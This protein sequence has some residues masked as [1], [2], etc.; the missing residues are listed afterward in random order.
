MST[1]TFRGL[2]IISLLTKV[3]G[4]GCKVATPTM[5]LEPTTP[6][7][8]PEP[9]T[10]APTPAA[11]AEDTFRGQ[12][13]ATLLQDITKFHSVACVTTVP[14]VV[15]PADAENNPSKNITSSETTPSSETSS[16]LLPVANPLPPFIPMDEV[17]ALEL[18]TNDF[19][20]Q[21]SDKCKTDNQNKFNDQLNQCATYLTG[22]FSANSDHTDTIM[23]TFIS[24]FIVQQGCDEVAEPTTG[25][26]EVFRGESVAT[27]LK[28]IK[29]FDEAACSVTGTGVTGTGGTGTGGTGTGG[30]GT[31]GTGTG[32]TGTGG[33]G[34]GG[35]GTSG[36]GTSVTTGGT[37]TEK[38]TEV[39]WTGAPEVTDEMI[40]EFIVN[41]KCVRATQAMTQRA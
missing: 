21:I 4:L 7:P 26:E 36:T 41:K 8:T 11:Q 24:P 30:T 31:G 34:T 40:N 25:V 22:N 32:G 10:P 12:S 18:C 5:P 17:K 20:A 35:T 38:P 9:T 33:T 27:L 14:G 3:E 6:A 1:D 28:D 37:V 15:E 2:S 16:D 29:K 13:V 23:S 19:N 39:G